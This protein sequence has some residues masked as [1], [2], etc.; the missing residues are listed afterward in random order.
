MSRLALIDGDIIVYRIACKKKWKKVNPLEAPSSL[1]NSKNPNMVEVPRTQEEVDKDLH[2]LL[3]TVLE[4][5]GTT[6]YVGFISGTRRE[7]FR[8]EVSV[9]KEYKGNRKGEKPEWHNYVQ[10][11]LLSHY[12]YINMGSL[13]ADDGM[14]ILQTRDIAGLET[15]IA[16]DDKDL[17]GTEGLHYNIRDAILYNVTKES[18]TD[19]L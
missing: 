1:P 4:N 11:R 13:E 3:T 9:T 18:A 10:Q 7:C 16:T 12:G 5:I 19:M 6:M 8:T 14:S 15:V 17:D 2:S